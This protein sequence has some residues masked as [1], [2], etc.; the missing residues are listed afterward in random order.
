MGIVIPGAL[1][2]DPESRDSGFARR[3]PGN[4]F[5]R[6]QQLRVKCGFGFPRPHCSPHRAMLHYPLPA[7]ARRDPGARRVEAG[8]FMHSPDPPVVA[9]QPT[10]TRN[11]RVLIVHTAAI[12]VIA[13]LLV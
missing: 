7:R 11:R 2:P 5:R 3:A 6:W 9:D 13:V 8:V 1:A 4:D 10:A 12:F